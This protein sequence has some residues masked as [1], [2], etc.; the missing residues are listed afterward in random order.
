[1]MDIFRR[2]AHARHA[3]LSDLTWWWCPPVHA[4]SRAVHRVIVDDIYN[5]LE[6]I[7]GTAKC[8]RS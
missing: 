1:M 7:N 8:S 4:V 6:G 5:V 3:I 2:A